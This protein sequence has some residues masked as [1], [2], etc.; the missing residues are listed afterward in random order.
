MSDLQAFRSWCAGRLEATQE[1][2]A[3]FELGQ[4]RLYQNERDISEG[5]MLHLRELA[6]EMREL[7]GVA[8][9]A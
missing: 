3:L 9:D 4:L 7:L 2:L 5:H 6:G 8:P 1:T